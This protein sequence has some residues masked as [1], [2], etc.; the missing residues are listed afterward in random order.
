MGTIK[1]ENMS[2][3]NDRKL[4]T[5][6]KLQKHEKN[7]LPFTNQDEL[8]LVYKF[9]PHIIL[10]CDPI[11]A[12]CRQEYS[13]P[14]SLKWQYG[15]ISGGSSPILIGDEYLSFFHSWRETAS[16]G[17]RIYYVG[18]YT[19]QDKPP[20]GILRYTTSPLW[21]KDFYTTP[22]PSKHKVL[23]PTSAFLDKDDVI[24]VYG[25]NDATTK[26]AKFNLEELSRLMVIN[27]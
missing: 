14:C 2:Y 15:I 10:N 16:H 26:Q 27:K 22:S 12:Y 7:W 5:N 8:Y 3:F 6:F 4:E 17:P 20:F 9:Q 25:E 19:F 21:Q 23:F 24:M 1:T 11:T 18:A 13:T